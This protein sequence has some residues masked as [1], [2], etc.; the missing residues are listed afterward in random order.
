MKSQHRLQKR[1]HC[2]INGIVDT[3]NSSTDSK[4]GTEM[5]ALPCPT[6]RAEQNLVQARALAAPYAT[7]VPGTA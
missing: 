6:R 4:N 1:Q 3:V 7:S 2:P 5:E